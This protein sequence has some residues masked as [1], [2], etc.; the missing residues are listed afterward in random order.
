[1]K[2]GSESKDNLLFKPKDN[3]SN[4][5]DVLLDENILAEES[6]NDDGNIATEGKH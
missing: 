5:N 2:L 6:L 1:M 3:I 4:F